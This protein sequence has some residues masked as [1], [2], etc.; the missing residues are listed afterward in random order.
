MIIFGKIL[1]QE[2]K[3]YIS[4]INNYLT[5]VLFLFIASILL[6]FSLGPDI[7]VLQSVMPGFIWVILAFTV[8]MAV[9]KMYVADFN[10]GFLE[11]ILLSSNHVIYFACAKVIVYWLI[12]LVPMLLIMPFLL[13][14]LELDKVII[15]KLLLSISLGSPIM[16]ILGAVGSAIMVGKNKN[17]ALFCLLILP[18]FIPIIIFGSLAVADLYFL[19]IKILFSL[20]L[21]FAVLF[22][23]F[24]EYILKKSV[25]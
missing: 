19:N 24:I 7:T 5:N 12:N 11:E 21:L 1:L 22:I 25:F 8:I 13:I 2:A 15:I 6:P 23:N 3:I 17:S 14:A 10:S 20:L 16:F 9:E 18:F 4:D